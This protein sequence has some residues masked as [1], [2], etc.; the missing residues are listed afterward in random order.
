MLKRNLFF[1]FSVTIFA[2]ASLVLDLFNYNPFESGKL[3]FVN[4]FVS[5]HLTILGLGAF[6]IYYSKLFLF[7]DKLIYTSFWPSVRQSFFLATAATTLLFLSGVGLLDWWV[8]TSLVIV[9][10]LME[11]FFETKRPAKTEISS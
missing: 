8:G 6:I 9:V 7:K 11:L 5:L 3:V 2:F 4:F 10:I 1:L